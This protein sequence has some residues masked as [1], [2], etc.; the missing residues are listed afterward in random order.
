MNYDKEAAASIEEKYS[1]LQSRYNDIFLETFAF[2]GRLKNERAKEFFQHGVGRRLEI[3]KGCIDNMF[4]L[5]PVEQ[6]EKLERSN[7]LAV[8]I[9][10]HAFL[11]NVY[12]IIENLGLALAYENKLVGEQSKYNMH[13]KQVNL[14]NGKFQKL[15]HPTLAGYLRGET[16]V[17]W[18]KDYAKNYRDALAQRIPP[19]VPPSGL[20]D[21]EQK[22][23]S[24]IE[25]ELQTLSY[26]NDLARIEALRDEEETLGSAIALFVHSFSEKANLVYLHLQIV[27]DFLTIEEL[28]RKVMGN[29]FFEPQS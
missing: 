24:D 5:F 23:F 13:P 9:N 15:L 26:W 18:Y 28:L 25:K 4:R 21:A 2:S 22:R 14:F 17:K 10:L 3:L 1:E 29:F 7:R 8:E 16:V 19:Y 20:N 12:G 11:I 27:T 6:V